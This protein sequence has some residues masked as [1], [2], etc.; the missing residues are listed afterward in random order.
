M[1][2]EAD[3]EN[4]HAISLSRSRGT[5]GFALRAK[6]TWNGKGWYSLFPKRL[7]RGENDRGRTDAL[8]RRS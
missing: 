5:Y 1:I 3:S 2:H 4:G 6:D 7:W 8:L